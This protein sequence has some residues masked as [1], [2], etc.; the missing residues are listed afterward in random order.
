MNDR[1]APNTWRSRLLQAVD[2]R[3]LRVRTAEPLPLR[4][5]QRRVFVLPTR[6]GWV[7]GLTLMA[8]LTA[9]INYTLSLGFALTFLLAGV[10]IASI[11]HAFRTLIHLD[12]DAGP[13]PPVHCGEPGCFG[14][15]LRH[16]RNRPRQAIRI[17]N[18][19]NAVTVDLP[20]GGHLTVG[21]S[22]PTTARGWQ[23][24]GRVTLETV[25]PLGLIRAWSV[26]TPD[27]QLLVYPAL[28]E[29]PPP[30]PAGDGTTR[31]APMASGVDEF[32]GLR[33]HRPTDSPRQIAWKAVAR[34]GT[35]VSKHFQ[36]GSAGPLFFDWQQLP[37]ALNDEARLQRLARW[38]VDAARSNNSWTLSLPGTRL[39]P[40]RGAQHLHR[41]LRA[42]ALYGQDEHV[43]PGR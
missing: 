39:G 37:P 12:I 4:L 20:P 2:R 41:C 29:H 15:A 23:A 34:S 7:F 22:V 38:V 19:D 36:G 30:P 14:L 5:P 21:L 10:G 27:I 1:T 25:Y 9:S 40:D 26:T 8:M 6:A 16:Q 3:L 32:A 33:A 17:R 31:S 43:P 35:L 42:L 24:I 13:T 11:F 18:A 28:E